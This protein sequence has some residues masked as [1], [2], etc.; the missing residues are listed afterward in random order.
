MTSTMSWYVFVC[1]FTSY[2]GWCSKCS[3]CLNA[4]YEREGRL[5]ITKKR[6]TRFLYLSK[7][8]FLKYMY[9]WSHYC[10]YFQ[11]HYLISIQLFYFQFHYSIFNPTILFSITLIYF[12]SHYFIFNPTILLSILLFYFNPTIW[13]HP[14][15]TLLV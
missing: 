15:P 5:C 12:Q 13:C 14:T 8:L 7:L 10:V 2:N 1:L 6:K 3:L 4:H 9:I 11:S